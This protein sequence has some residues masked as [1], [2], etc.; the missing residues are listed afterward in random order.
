MFRRGSSAAVCGALLLAL[1]FSCARS[2][3]ERAST[4]LPATVMVPVASVPPLAGA[5]IPQPAP[6]APVDYLADGFASTTTKRAW[7]MFR[8]PLRS[9][10]GAAP[11]NDPS[12]VDRYSRP[13]QSAVVSEHE[14]SAR[15][16]VELTDLRFLLYADRGALGLVLRAATTL[17]VGPDIPADGA[18]GVRVAPGVVLIERERQASMVRVEGESGRL[19]FEG[20]AAAEAL[21][22][23]YDKGEVEV[24]LGNGL[25]REG[26]KVLSSPGGA[27]LAT[28]GTDGSAK[29]EF[30][31]R[32]EP[33]NGATAG[34]QRIRLRTREVDLRGVVAAAD[35][36]PNPPGHS[37][38]G[39]SHWSRGGR[40][41]MSDSR[42]GMLPEGTA[43]YA[44]VDRVRVGRVLKPVLVYY[45]F[46][47]PDLDGFLTVCLFAEQLGRVT[48]LANAADIE[49]EP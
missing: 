48:A 45:G 14:D 29:P 33:E 26:T 25:V 18:A 15:I 43:L 2:G 30:V 5:S 23:V 34:W 10:Q 28:F 16:V 27:T 49:P 12:P 7:L 31:F 39:G 19:N 41:S 13:M 35:Y 37:R 20:W 47:A 21:G 22:V 32:V 6:V 42:R 44:P 24:V 4:R 1:A 8:G 17:S 3:P 9:S 36:K 38:L 11:L 46:S 40:G